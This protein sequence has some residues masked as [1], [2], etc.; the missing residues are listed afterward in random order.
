[1]IKRFFKI[2]PI[3]AAGLLIALLSIGCG[4]E[5]PQAE[6]QAPEEVVT[7]PSAEEANL[8]KMIEELKKKEFAVEIFD[9]GKSVGKYS[10]N[11]RESWRSD[12]PTD[13]NSY[14][15]YNADQK[16]GWIVSGKTATEV[17]DPAS[18]QLYQL[19]SPVAL[20]S[21]Y[22][23]FGTI[24]RTGGTD[25]VWEWSVPGMGSLTIEFKGPDGLISKVIA[26]DPQSGRSEIEFRY[27]N[28]GDV[29]DSLFE[30]PSDVT[31]ESTGTGP[32]GFGGSENIEVPSY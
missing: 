11:G 7:T 21:I 20:L 18:L 13:P 16:K 19:S 31:V 6:T 17:T 10:Q 2:V 32:G 12:D 27:S 3:A 26:E 29:P 9:A 24:P 25:D 28:V 14:T 23:A 22:G 30:L 15:I 4:E 1:M 8:N 5:E